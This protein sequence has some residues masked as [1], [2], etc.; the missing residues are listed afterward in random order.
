MWASLS[1]VLFTGSW[2]YRCGRLIIGGG[3]WGAYNRQFTVFHDY[4]S[5]TFG[6]SFLFCTWRF[7]V[8]FFFLSA[9]KYSVGTRQE[10]SLEIKPTSHTGL[11]L[12]SWN[13]KGDYI[14]LEM[15][16]GNVSNV[17]GRCDAF[18]L[19][20]KGLRCQIKRWMRRIYDIVTAS[21]QVCL[22]DVIIQR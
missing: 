14:V 18:N 22:L 8:V 5:V 16:N 6:A 19:N 2:T 1:G 20:L 10:I 12:S 17:L 7:C 13:A 11:L 21:R 3:G 15:S 9:D 4:S